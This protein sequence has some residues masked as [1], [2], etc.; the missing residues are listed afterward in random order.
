MSSE[1]RNNVLECALPERYAKYTPSE[2]QSLVGPTVLWFITFLLAPLVV[3]LVYS[4]LE[5][6]SFSVVYQFSLEAWNNA[7]FQPVVYSVFARTLLIGVAVTLL[8][9][10]VGY[11]LAYYLRFYTSELGGIIMLLFLVIP[12]W[13]SELIRT[14]GW[15]PIL[16]KTGVINQVL[17]ISGIIDKPLSWLLYSPV[18]Q[19]VG[20]LQNY[21][22]FMAAPIF[23][24]L[25]QVD[26]GL[27]D[28]SET[29]RGDPVAT[30]R[31]V[32]W[33]LS[34]PGVTIG[35]IFVFVLSIGNFT[36]PQFLSGG[37]STI[38][39]LI[40]LSVNNGLNYPSAAAL[41]FA[42][43][44]VIFLIVYALIRTVDIS[45]IAQG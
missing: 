25:S 43:L 18:S 21:V 22:V 13:T 31:N 6:E 35:S 40:Y 12:F 14:L 28:A 15:I 45:E 44:V 19:V 39:T 30:F 42:L 32:T 27:L 36:I 24:S 9:L 16:G 23:I 29:L 4:F 3:I 11:P 7:V 1:Q 5:Y 2:V 38:S 17:I 34:L 26:E 8:C 33:P 10:V 41:S 37:K 20:Y